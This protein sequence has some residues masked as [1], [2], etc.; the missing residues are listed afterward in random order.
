MKCGSHKISNRMHGVTFR[1]FASHK[2][3]N[4]KH[5]ATFRKFAS[6]KISNR[7]HGVTFRK[8]ASHKISNR[9]HGVTFR[10]F[11]SHRI[12]NKI[13]GVTFQR[14]E[15]FI[16]VLIKIRSF[17]G[18]AFS[19]TCICLPCHWLSSQQLLEPEFFFWELNSCFG[20]QELQ[21]SV[22]WSINSTEF[23]V[24]LPFSQEPSTGPVWTCSNQ[25]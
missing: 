23:A 18:V 19:V 11:A 13:H 10:I 2:I 20:S 9:M 24:L 7:K 4:R 5:G 25:S 21:C 16:K 12:S 1:K 22:S 17:S 3:S 6:H 14:T 8:F 15:I